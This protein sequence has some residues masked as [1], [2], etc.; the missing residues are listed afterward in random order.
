FTEGVTNVDINDFVLTSSG[1]TGA[2]ITS[3]TGSGKM[4]NI[5]VNTGFG[6]G[7]VRVD[8]P[9]GA[10]INDFIG[11]PLA[12]VPYTDGEFYTL[13]RINTLTPSATPTTTAT[14]TITPTRTA[15]GTRTST[16]TPSA[17]PTPTSTPTPTFTRTFTITRTPTPVTPSNTPT[18]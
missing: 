18:Q 8:V 15:T 4:R 12:G 3:V 2:S 13:A 5:F 17:T 11:N 7:T 9:I 10:T 6:D 1:V 16:R 14:S